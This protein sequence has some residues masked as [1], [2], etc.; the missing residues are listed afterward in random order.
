MPRHV[1][2]M[3]LLTRLVALATVTVMDGHS[4]RGDDDDTMT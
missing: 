1:C 3:R 2:G 4:G